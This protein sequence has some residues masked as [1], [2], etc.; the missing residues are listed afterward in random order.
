MTD[1]VLDC[2]RIPLSPIYSIISE[3][4]DD[5]ILE[6]HTPADQLDRIVKHVKYLKVFDNCACSD[7]IKA[8]AVQMAV[9]KCR[10][11][12]FNAHVLEHAATIVSVSLLFVVANTISIQDDASP[13]TSGLAAFRFVAREDNRRVARSLGDDFGAN[14]NFQP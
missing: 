7:M 2:S 13:V 1:E 10:T 6:I 11:R 3:S 5:N 4:R 9:T 12:I 14:L 8:D